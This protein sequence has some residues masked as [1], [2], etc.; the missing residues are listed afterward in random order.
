MRY[1]LKRL[2]ILSA[3]F[4]DHPNHNIRYLALKDAAADCPGV[5]RVLVLGCG[6]GFVEYMLTDGWETLSVDISEAQIETARAVNR[7]KRNRQFFVGDIF[8]L[9]ETLQDRVFDMVII[10]EVIEHIEQDGEALRIAYGRLRP[11][12]YFLLTVPNRYRFHNALR[13]L[14]R[15]APFLMTAEHLREYEPGA[16]RGLLRQ[17]GFEI[18]RRRGVWF[19]F[20]RPAVAERFIGP[21][22]RVRNLLAMLFPG[23]ATYLMF[24]CR[25]P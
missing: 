15:R 9:G 22:S 12:G 5:K 1:E 16:I 3:F 4:P 6:R 17:A 19:E 21:T 20:P 7:Y 23:W 25:K 13:R 11:G 14:V 18:R 8:N 2:E 10:S 24:V